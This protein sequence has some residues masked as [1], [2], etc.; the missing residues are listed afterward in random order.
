MRPNT[1]ASAALF[2]LATAV[3]IHERATS[4]D[5]VIVGC[6][7]AGIVIANRLSANPATSVLCIEAGP[8]YVK[9]SKIE[10]PLT[11]RF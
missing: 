10:N 6:G 11:D 3:P 4:Y 1:Y 9:F 2:G 5:Y 8:L 7:T